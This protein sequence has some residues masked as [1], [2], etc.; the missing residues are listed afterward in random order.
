LGRRG[1]C[2][3]L[4]GGSHRRGIEGRR[5]PL[6]D[7][8]GVAGTLTQA[9]TES[10]AVHLAHEARLAVNDLDGTFVAGRNAGAAAVALAFVDVHNVS[11]H[12]LFSCTSSGSIV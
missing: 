1:G 3:G 12:G 8:D 6:F 11:F 7:R 4:L 9:G 10:V 2:R 5:F